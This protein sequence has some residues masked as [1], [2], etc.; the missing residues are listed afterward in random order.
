MKDAQFYVYMYL[1]QNNVP[2]YIGKGKD[3]RRYVSIHLNTS[4]NNFL[5]RKILKLGQMNIK[6]H[7]LHKNLTE[8]NAFYWERYWI[9][10]IGRRITKEGPLCNITEGGEG[11][12]GYKHT[13]ET[14]R[15]IGLA[16]ARRKR[17]KETRYKISEANKGKHAHLFGRLVSEETR[18]KISKSNQGHISSLKGIP[19]SDE[20]RQKIS[21]AQKG[22]IVSEETKQKMRKSHKK[23]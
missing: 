5:K 12:S 1:D 22:K 17:S 19:R 21:I 11:S 9:K 20:V 14:K 8:E 4:P 2:F 16:S 13:N 15:K 18:N 10:Y 23:R 7:F 3:I 6:I